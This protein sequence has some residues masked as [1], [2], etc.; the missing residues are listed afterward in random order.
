MIEGLTYDQLI[1][2]IDSVNKLIGNP[3]TFEEITA[4]DSPLV[5]FKCEESFEFDESQLYIIP[6]DN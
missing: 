2:L 3:K 1:E 4:I 6:A 5:D